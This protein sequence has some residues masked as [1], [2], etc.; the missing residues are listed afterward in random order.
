MANAEWINRYVSIEK[1]SEFGVEPSVAQTFGEVDDESFKQTFDLLTRSDMSRQVASK[2]VT[3]TKY[4]EGSINFAV[5]PDDFMGNILLAFL[6]S[7]A[8][9]EFWDDVSVDTQGFGYAEGQGELVTGTIDDR[10]YKAGYWE[11]LNGQQDALAVAYSANLGTI[12]LDNSTTNWGTYAGLTVGA[13]YDG[14]VHLG[15]GAVGKPGGADSA[16]TGFYFSYSGVTGSTLTGVIEYQT[17]TAPTNTVAASFS[18]AHSNG[19]VVVD[20]P[21]VQFR[22]HKDGIIPGRPYF[23]ITE[24]LARIKTS[25]VASEVGKNAS[26][27]STNPYT[28]TTTALVPT[29]LSDYLAGGSSGI[30]GATATNTTAAATI[31]GALGGANKH[32]FQEPVTADDSYPSFTIRVG[33]EAKEH[34][35]T[36]MVATRL[37]LSANLNEYVMASADWLGQ[38]EATPTAIQTG[39]SFSGNDVDALHFSG[40][41]LFV[42]GSLATSTKVQSI[43]LEININR[44]LDSAYAVGS[45]TIQRIP[46][47]RTREITGSMEFNEIIYSDTTGLKGEPTYADLATSTA[48]HKLHGGAG[49]PALKLKFQDATDADHIEIILYNVRFEA[50]E[51]SVSGR[52]PARMTVNFQAFYDSKEKGA[53]KAILVKMKGSNLKTSGY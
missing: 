4:G 33:R 44:D 27:M 31:A 9:N 47:S 46:P 13:T 49:R 21:V 28:I 7:S 40:A 11:V 53:A 8:E 30:T 24:P 51:A 38:S 15:Y 48:V 2:A 6:P 39:V 50:P 22:N 43:S 36:G 29:D 5:Q 18:D 52:D 35:F 26:Q 10:V 3:N 45:N 19:T 37:S 25:N 17:Y 32:V 23:Y 16:T 20:T 42:D 14:V 34:T 41:E 1:E 12:T